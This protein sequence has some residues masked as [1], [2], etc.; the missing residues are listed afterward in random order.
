MKT[1]IK[2]SNKEL[3][4]SHF[5]PEI[6][7]KKSD[8]KVADKF[9]AD[10]IFQRKSAQTQEEKLKYRIL[11]LKFRIE[12]FLSSR[13]SEK[14]HTFGSFLKEYASAVNLKSYELATELE[15]NRTQLSQIINTKVDPPN[16]LL[17]RLG[18][19][20]NNAIDS[21]LWYK[22]YSKEKE[23]EFTQILKERKLIEEQSKHVKKKL[24]VNI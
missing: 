15:F 3:A 17:I 7:P 1:S 22:L 24:A 21:R 6:K 18:L 4:E 23:V 14:E 19:H 11:Q 9:L 16:Y 12:D 2:Y 13:T 5:I 10:L 8:K 20:S